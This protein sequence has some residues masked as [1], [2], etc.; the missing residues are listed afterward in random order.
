ML[1]KV[2]REKSPRAGNL[3]GS[4][5]EK[6]RF[7]EEPDTEVGV[8]RYRLVAA[9]GIVTL[10]ACLSLSTS[11]AMGMSNHVM[12][13][14][15]VGAYHLVLKIGPAE[16]MGGMNGE[17]MLHGKMARCSMTMHMA[18]GPSG[19][20]GTARCNH[21]V[22]LHVYRLSNDE[23]VHGARVSIRMYCLKMHMNVYVPIMTMMDPKIGMRDYHYG[24]NVHAR[25]GVYRVFV[26]VNGTKAEFRGVHLR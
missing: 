15:N 8:T 21:H 11:L 22:E 17:R 4:S 16:K 5:T 26:R 2:T 9:L 10:M 25:N 23:V 24:N 14:V 3:P 20:M 12:R 6:G 7:G 13:S 19:M 1:L 18:V